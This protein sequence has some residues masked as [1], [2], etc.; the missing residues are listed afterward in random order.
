MT[1][2]TP[3]QS[4]LSGVGVLDKASL[5]LGVLE[6]GPASLSRLVS[7]TGLKRPTVHRLVLA[8]ERLRLLARD[9]QGRFILGPRLGMMAMEA[10]R[11]HLVLSADPV[12]NDLRD[13]TGA[14][15]RLYRRRGNMRVCVAE[16]AAAGPGLRDRVPVGA[17]LPL[18][19]GPVSQVLLAWERPEDLYDGLRGAQFTAATLSG[20]RRQGWAQSI[21]GREHGIAAVAAPVRGPGGRVMAALSISGPV[22]R[23]TSTPGRLYG[24]VVIDAAVRLSGGIQR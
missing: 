20:V 24:S 21:G 17:A 15:A 9:A 5:L 11:D 8:L 2:S 16:A 3:E 18:N 19:A 22:T 13:I 1:T 12:L 7:D 6:G 14:S 4:A 10:C 23:M